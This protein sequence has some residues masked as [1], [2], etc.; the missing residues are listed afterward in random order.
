MEQKTMECLIETF[1][2]RIRDLEFD[3]FC[4]KRKTDRLKKEIDVMH[5]DRA[6]MEKQLEEKISQ[7]ELY[8]TI[9]KE[10]EGLG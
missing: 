7:L 6:Q 10:A 2:G 3:Q 8:W 9:D 5:E 4:E 1:A